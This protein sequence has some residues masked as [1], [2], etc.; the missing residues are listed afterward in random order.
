[1]NAVEWDCEVRTIRD[2]VTNILPRVDIHPIYNRRFKTKLHGLKKA[3]KP[4]GIMNSIVTGFDIGEVTLAEP[5]EK[6]DH[7]V[8]DGSNRMDAIQKYCNNQFPIHDSCSN[9]VF[10]GKYYKDL[11]SDA[12]KLLLDYRV[13]LVWYRN[14]SNQTKGMLFRLRNGGTPVNPMEMLNAYGRIPIANMIRS[15]ARLIPDEQT[16]PHQLFSSYI[17]PQKNDVEW[18]YLN[19]PNSRLFHDEMVARISYMMYHGC[20]I[21]ACDHKE[22]LQAM[23]TDNSL[24]ESVVASIAKKVNACLD[25]MLIIAK[26]CEARKNRGLESHEFTM[27][28]RWYVYFVSKKDSFKVVDSN[29]FYDSFDMAMNRLMTKNSALHIPGNYANRPIC[30]PKNAFASG[31]SQHSSVQRIQ[32]TVEWLTIAGFDPL[33]SGFVQLIDRRETFN[34][35]DVENKWIEQGYRCWVTGEVL[36]REDARGGHIKAR[37]LGGPTD[38]MT[39]LVVVHVDHNRAMGTMDAEEYREMWQRKQ[40]SIAAE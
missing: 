34:R 36:A 15:T 4:Q 1:M 16:T 38:P 29:G 19:F 7:E 6:H 35:R 17:N 3:S 20:T 23:Y 37:S 21:V 22:Q 18:K 26:A 13:R 8:L 10:A 27:L 25:F 2:I 14:V 31:C 28:Y 32:K 12:Q 39:N 40:S 24:T 30:G 33:D 11:S 9:A 5:G